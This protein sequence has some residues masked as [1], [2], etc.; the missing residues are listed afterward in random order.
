MKSRL[1]ELKEEM[2]S[3]KDDNNA[4]RADEINEQIEDTE[5]QLKCVEDQMFSDY[6]NY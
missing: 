3:A 1:T 4:E 5:W 2:E 6:S